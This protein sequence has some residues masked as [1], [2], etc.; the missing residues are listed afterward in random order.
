MVG[1]YVG[2]VLLVLTPA[3]LFAG[4]GSLRGSPESMIRQ[5]NIAVE[6]E[7]TFAR[8]PANIVNEVEAGVLT[9]LTG[10]ENY[11]FAGVSFAYAVPEVR[12]LVERLSAQYRTACGERL[13]VTSL[14]RPKNRQPRNSHVLSVHPAGMA[15]D[16]RVSRVKACRTWLEGTLLSLESQGVL[17]VTQERHPAH[18]HVA[19]FPTPYRRY[20]ARLEGTKS[21]TSSPGVVAQSKP[22]VVHAAMPGSRFS[23]G[24][25]QFWLPLIYTLLCAL[26]AVA[27]LTRRLHQR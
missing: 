8:T 26:A 14:T 23:H 19:V 21:S 24:D 3:T 1:K 13:V 7:L 9:R 18:Y 5:H 4:E 16:L 2:A 15:M 27:A 12:M 22:T 11:R 6:E 20:V 25:T 10:N 17:D